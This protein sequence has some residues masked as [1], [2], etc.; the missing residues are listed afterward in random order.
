VGVIWSGDRLFFDSFGTVELTR[1]VTA[2]LNGRVIFCILETTRPGQVNARSMHQPL[3]QIRMNRCEFIH[4]RVKISLPMTVTKQPPSPST[5]FRGETILLPKGPAHLIIRPHFLSIDHHELPARPSLE[6]LFRSSRDQKLGF[7]LIEGVGG[8][9]H[10]CHPA[11]RLLPALARAKSPRAPGHRVGASKPE[12][13]R[14]ANWMYFTTPKRAGSLAT[15]GRIF[16]WMLR[17]KV[18]YQTI[19]NVA[20]VSDLRRNDPLPTD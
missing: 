15:I 20:N 2:L 10:H 8:Y 7:T 17:L 13:N 6:L 9:C 4:H 18:Q 16:L 19:D 14:L 5:R 3:V 11:S 12:A 1:A